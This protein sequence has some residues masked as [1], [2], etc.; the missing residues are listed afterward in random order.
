[1]AQF[2]LIAK[3][4]LSPEPPGKDIAVFLMGTKSRAPSLQRA[5]WPGMAAVRQGQRAGSCR[6]AQAPG[7]K[8]GGGEG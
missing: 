2:F 7:E 6:W 3:L 4:M 8:A 1:M 5:A